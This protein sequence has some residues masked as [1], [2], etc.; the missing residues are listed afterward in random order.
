MYNSIFIGLYIKIRML[1]SFP[2]K[3]AENQV[4]KS[5]CIDEKPEPFFALNHGHQRK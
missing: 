1:K 2:Q 3:T 5:K 4:L